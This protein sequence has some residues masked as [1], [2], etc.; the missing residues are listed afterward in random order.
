MDNLRRLIVGQHFLPEN[1]R[2]LSLYRA[3]DPTVGRWMSRDPIGE[4]GGLN[5]YGYV[6]DN[7]TVFNDSFGLCKTLRLDISFSPGVNRAVAVTRAL[8][9]INAL[10]KNLA[11]CACPCITV[12]AVFD[13]VPGSSGWP[14]Y[15]G[16]TGRILFGT[17]KPGSA[18]T[19]DYGKGSIITPT[20][21][22]S[23]NVLSHELGH[24]AGYWN[25]TLP[26]PKILGPDVYGRPFNPNHSG[27]PE[28]LMWPVDNGES[29]VDDIWC[30][31]MQK[32]AR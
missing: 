14:N 24:Q 2:Y 20:E 11:K 6:S 22:A 31:K 4:R 18:G 23:P 28:N 12:E 19:T 29:G 5:L 3:Y 16:A 27:D 1:G 32:L 21:P 15:P 9:M 26:G 8:G 17:P 25:P 13:P 7:P 30:N 10:G